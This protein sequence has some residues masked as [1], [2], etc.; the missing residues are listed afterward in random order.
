VVAITRCA[1]F[2]LYNV[3]AFQVVLAESGATPDCQIALA[4]NPVKPEV[5]S[6][7][8]ALEFDVPFSWLSP[9]DYQVEQAK[10]RLADMT[11]YYFGSQTPKEL[12]RMIEDVLQKT[13]VGGILPYLGTW[14]GKLAGKLQ[15]ASQS[16][17]SDCRTRKR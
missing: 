11:E 2:T 17:S 14:Q 15:S 6:R 7:L 1:H 8:A 9:P 4:S 12:D 3:I 13:G 16:T 5:W 10:Q